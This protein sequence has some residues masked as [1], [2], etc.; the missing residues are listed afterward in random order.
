[1]ERGQYPTPQKEHIANLEQIMYIVFFAIPNE[2]GFRNWLVFAVHRAF[3]VG[4][5]NPGHPGHKEHGT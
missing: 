5:S 3:A 4:L 1:M 2:G